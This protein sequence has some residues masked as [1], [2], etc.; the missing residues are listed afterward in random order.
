MNTSL[1]NMTVSKRPN[2]NLGILNMQA[3]NT[4]KLAGRTHQTLGKLCQANSQANIRQANPVINHIITTNVFLCTLHTQ[5]HCCLPLIDSQACLDAV[6]KVDKCLAEV[7]AWMSKCKLKLSN[8]KTECMVVTNK[9]NNIHQTKQI[10]VQILGV[11]VLVSCFCDIQAWY[12]TMVQWHVQLLHPQVALNNAARLDMDSQIRPHHS[13]AHSSL[14]VTCEG[15]HCLQASHY[16]PQCTPFTECTYW[17][18]R[19][20]SPISSNKKCTICLRPL[21]SSHVKE[22]RV[23]W[24]IFMSSVWF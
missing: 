5:L 11:N 18:Q 3:T 9:N 22:L 1:Y 7:R 10:S 15:A 4:S 23:T 2:G 6:K 21:A 13:C 14:L 20:F 16:Y 24:W 12:S 19:V 8:S 17:S